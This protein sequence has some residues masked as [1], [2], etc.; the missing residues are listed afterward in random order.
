[1]SRSPDRVEVAELRFWGAP[2]IALEADYLV[3]PDP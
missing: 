1:M 3:T 2:Y